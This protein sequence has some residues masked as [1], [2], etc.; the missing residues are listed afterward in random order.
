MRHLT[1]LTCVSSDESVRPTKTVSL[2]GELVHQSLLSTDDD[3]GEV[4]D[5][6]P[7][8]K[9]VKVEGIS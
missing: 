6:E 2:P 9:V 3:D 5:R 8:T 7:F 1:I 4:G